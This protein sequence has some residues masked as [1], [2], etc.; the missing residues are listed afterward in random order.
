MSLDIEKTKEEARRI[1]LGLNR[2]DILAVGLFGSLARGT[3]HDRSDIDIFVITEKCLSLKEQDE[4]YYAFSELIG[5]FHRDVTVLA[6]DLKGVKEVPCWHTLQMIKDAQ[7]IVDH[8]GVEEIFKKIL[9][10]AAEKGIIYDEKDR[11]FR[12]QRARR[13]VFTFTE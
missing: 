13:M 7:F 3:Y 12:L 9:Q 10:Q 8:A 11:L 2:R 4:L 6:Y 1:A 5:V